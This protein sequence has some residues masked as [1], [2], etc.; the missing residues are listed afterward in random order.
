MTTRKYKGWTIS[1][2]KN[3]HMYCH[4]LKA[5]KG[6]VIYTIPCEDSPVSEG[7][8]GIWP[9]ELQTDAST[10]SSLIQAIHDWA[11]D[12][13][14]LYRIYI[15]RDCFEP[16]ETATENQAEQGGAGNPAKPGA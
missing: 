2:R 1:F 11:T 12:E 14:L 5:S 9:Y 10:Y 16:A 7:L 8:I 6:D 4:E 13:G 15:S 3:I